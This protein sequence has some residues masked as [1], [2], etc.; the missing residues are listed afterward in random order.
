MQANALPIASDTVQLA[1]IASGQQYILTV[2][3]TDDE[4]DQLNEYLLALY[5]WDGSEWIR[6]C[7]STV[8]VSANTVIATPDHLSLWSVLW[9]QVQVFLA[10]I[11]KN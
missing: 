9:R 3:Y 6:E 8:D 5:T 7:S 4:V 2:R 1:Q 10:L 11:L